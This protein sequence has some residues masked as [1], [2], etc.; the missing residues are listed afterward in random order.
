MRISK[1]QQMISRRISSGSIVRQLMRACALVAIVCSSSSAAFAQSYFPATGTFN[2]FLNQLNIS[3]CDNTNSVPVNVTMTVT[4]SGGSVL[5]THAYQIAAFGSAHIILNDIASIADKIG[6]Y[7]LDLPSSQLFLG[8]QVFCRTAFYRLNPPGAVKPFEYAYVVPVENP[9]S[10]ETSGIYNSIDPAGEANTTYN[11]LTIVNRDDSAFNATVEIRGADGALLSN[12]SVANLGSSQRVDI[13]LGHPSGQV[14]GV[15]RII[16]NDPTHLYDAVV[17]RYNP[18]GSGYNFAFPLK[19]LPSACTGKPV[20]VSTMNSGAT[21]PWVEMANMGDQ[22]AVVTVDVRDRF[23]SLLHTEQREIEPYKQFHFFAGNV[24]DTAGTGNVGTVT[25]SC[26]DPTDRLVVQAT[27]YGKDHGNPK[28]NW[29]YSSQVRPSAPAS[30]SAS[31]VAPVNTFAGIYNWLKISDSAGAGGDVDWQLYNFLGQSVAAGVNSLAAGGSI[32]QDLHTPMGVDS[33][34]FVQLD[35]TGESTTFGGEMLRVTLRSDNQD[36]GTITPIPAVVRQKG[37]NGS[38]VGNPQSLAGY[39]DNLTTSEIVR[40]LNV[41]EFG[42]SLSRIQE[43]QSAGLRATVDAMLDCVG[44]A[45]NVNMSSAD[46]AEAHDWQD[47]TFGNGFVGSYDIEGIDKWW[48]TFMH[49]S[50]CPLKEKLAFMLHDRF[51]SSCSVLSAS[52]FNGGVAMQHCKAH[53]STLRSYAKGSYKDLSRTMATDFLMLVWLNGNQNKCNPALSTEPDQNWARENLELFNIGEP[54]VFGAG[55]KYPLYTQTDIERAAGAAAGYSTEYDDDLD[56]WVVKFTSQ[57]HCDS[58]ITLWEGTPFETTGSFKA[59]DLANVMYS[60]RPLDTGRYIGSM[61]FNTFCHAYPSDQ[62][63]NQLA[64]IL[65]ANNWRLEPVIRAVLTSEACFSPEAKNS[66]V[67]DPLTFLLG[68]VK[69]TGIKTKTNRIYDQLLQMTG[70]E[71]L[72]S[73]IDVFGFKWA[74]LRFSDNHESK[75]NNAFAVQF[76]NAITNLYNN[77]DGDFQGEDAFDYCSLLPYS[78]ATSSEVID[79]LATLMGLEL[80]SE[81]RSKLIYY[82]DN[83]A[84]SIG[85]GE[86]R[87]DPSLFDGRIA[88]HCKDRLSGALWIMAVLPQVITY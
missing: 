9:Q 11:W 29:A 67:K 37:D 76:M 20:A 36:L 14:T 78:T 41:T 43:V 10:G 38:F 46:L 73:P 8:D 30:Q 59:E 50:Q 55:M 23:G 86:Y 60:A 80:S 5:A 63:Q 87:I 71:G 81:V 54:Q 77:Q 3:E 68:F 48:I 15:Y 7:K 61:V 53:L 84:T 2:G 58:P 18:N 4:D 66:R 49:K 13:P 6:T 65:Q 83:K 45:D 69:A 72:M 52:P 24:I 34:G 56:E 12:T 25:V 21:L 51:A 85:G 33:V 1:A 79:H 47:D 75:Y 17:I 57:L 39:R 70:G 74:A 19:A 28:V 32:D 22:N 42:G 82:L 31:L 44:F 35:T 16:P 62:I 26:A 40:L 27:H 64:E 88:E